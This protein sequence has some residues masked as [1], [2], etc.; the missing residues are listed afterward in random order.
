ME[1]GGAEAEARGSLEQVSQTRIENGWR[2]DTNAV[3]RR[4]K[5]GEK[6]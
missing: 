2:S 6:V 5:P 3:A 1:R 4:G